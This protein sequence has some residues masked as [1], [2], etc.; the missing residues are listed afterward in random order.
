MWGGESERGEA[1]EGGAGGGGG[2][3]GRDGEEER[4]RERMFHFKFL[5]DG[6]RNTEEN[7]LSD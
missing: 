5:P 2:R 4:K 7:L 3:K 6:I 1:A